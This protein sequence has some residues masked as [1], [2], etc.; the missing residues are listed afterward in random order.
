V[1]TRNVLLALASVTVVAGPAAFGTPSTA[2]ADVPSACAAIGGTVNEFRWI[3][4]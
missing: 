1:T 3:R 4:P 2:A